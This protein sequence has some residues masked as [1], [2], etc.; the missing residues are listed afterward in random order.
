MNHNL[1]KSTWNKIAVFFNSS[2][3][4]FTPRFEKEKE[5]QAKI[6]K[7]EQDA[8]DLLWDKSDLT[9]E[10]L[11]QQYRPANQKIVQTFYYHLSRKY[12]NT[13]LILKKNGN[14]ICKSLFN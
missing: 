2:Y 9:W 13:P 6:A 14:I 7:V 10:Q 5:Q 8:L 3:K 4:R 1:H 12:Q 11:I